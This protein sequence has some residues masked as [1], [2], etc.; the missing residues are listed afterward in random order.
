MPVM[1][2]AARSTEEGIDTLGNSM[3]VLSGAPQ[4]NDQGN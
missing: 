2:Q 3:D 1:R 4:D